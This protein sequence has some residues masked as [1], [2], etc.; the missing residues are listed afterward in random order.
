MTVS[1]SGRQFEI[2]CGDTS[3]VVV[4]V[5][6]GLRALRL[7]NLETLDGYGE[8]EMASA[9]R[10]EVLIPWPNRIRDGHYLFQGQDL[11]LPLTE[12]SHHNAIHGL[13]RW[14]TWTATKQSAASVTMRHRLYPSPGYP[15]TLD[16][17]VAYTVSETE[18]TVQTSAINI[19]E[20]P[21][22]FGAG[23]H[24]YLRVGLPTIDS[25]L[26]RVPSETYLQVDDRMI[27]TGHASVSGTPF[28]FS[29][30]RP[31]GNAALDLCFTDLEREEDGRAQVTLRVPDDSLSLQLWMD[32]SYRHVMI[33]TGD[34]LSPPSRRRQGLAVEPMTCAPNAFNSGDGLMVLE[35]GQTVEMSWGISIDLTSG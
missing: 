9:G 12:P 11:Q 34:T 24:P 18:L 13:V 14:A 23:Q 21:C 17:A 30:S 16:L 6:G 22:P 7:D 4:E 5:G 31:I 1:P 8:N 28:D 15:F 33:F 19:G 27:P 35:P 20:E 32:L 29:A 26:L 25:A 3:A 10:G 2:R